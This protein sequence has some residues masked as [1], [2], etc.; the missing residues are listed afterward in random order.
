MTIERMIRIMAGF[1]AAFAGAGLAPAA[2]LRIG[3]VPRLHRLR[4][5]QPAAKRLH[6]L[7]PAGSCWPAGLQAWEWQLRGVI[8]E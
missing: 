6:R 8:Q 4:R 7:S 5:P 1:F 2:G 3:T